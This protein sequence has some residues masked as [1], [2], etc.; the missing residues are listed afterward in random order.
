MP[1]IRSESKEVAG[2]GCI[3]NSIRDKDNFELVI[4]THQ[5]DCLISIMVHRY[6]LEELINTLQDFDKKMRFAGAIR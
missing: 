6:D 4:P 1:T 2:I 3:Y 5:D